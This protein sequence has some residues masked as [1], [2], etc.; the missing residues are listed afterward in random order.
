MQRGCE[1]LNR[2]RVGVLALTTL[3][4]ADSLHGQG[5]LLG[6]LL[7]GQPSV[8][9]KSPQAF[10]EAAVLRIGHGCLIA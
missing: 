9:A 6:Q 3:E 5:G 4:G 1:R 2:V 8:P 7:L 10:A